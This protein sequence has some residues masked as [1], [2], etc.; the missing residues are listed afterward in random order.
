MSRGANKYDHKH[1]GMFN[2]TMEIS[3]E[4]F[5]QNI[6]LDPKILD[7]WVDRI[8]WVM[9]SDVKFAMG[10]ILGYYGEDDSFCEE[11]R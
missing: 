7:Q 8:W 5:D 2:L 1:W 4:S 10:F 9:D 11:Y 6:T 3:E